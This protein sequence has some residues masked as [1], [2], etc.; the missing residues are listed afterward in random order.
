MIRAIDEVSITDAVID[1]MA[2]TKSERLQEI[3]N[4]AVR[5]LHDF[6]RMEKKQFGSPSAKLQETERTDLSRDG[7]IPLIQSIVR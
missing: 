1:Q 3:V 6:A 4:A 2:S 5:H 7:Y